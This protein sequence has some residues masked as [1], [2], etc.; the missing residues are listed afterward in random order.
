MAREKTRSIILDTASKL[1]YQNGYNLVGINEIIEEANIA[2]ATLYSHFKSKEDLCIAYLNEKD[3]DLIDSLND[4]LSKKK[5]GNTRL[6]GIL[7]FLKKF[8][9]SEDF[10]GCWCIRTNAEMSNN[11]RIN[12]V[13]K[14]NKDKLMDLI[15]AEVK[16]NRDDLSKKTT[17][18]LAKTIYLL[19]E[20]AVM[21]SFLQDSQWPIDHALLLL[22][23]LV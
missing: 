11:A 5:K 21:E 12:V 9:Q 2:K 3:S 8:Y 4:F 6:L 14:S 18:E 23:K 13:I 1:F 7:E 15:L 16:F 10:R 22:K 19:Y 17:N 20:G